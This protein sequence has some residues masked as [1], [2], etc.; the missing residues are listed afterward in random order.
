MDDTLPVMVIDDE[1]HLRI[2]V[3]Q[4]LELAGYQPQ[5]FESAQQ[6]LDHLDR[7][8]SGVL[9]SDIRMPGMDG[10]A[11]LREVHQR[12]PDLPVILIT[13]HGDISTAVEAMREGAW[14]FLE[15]PFS[16]EQLVEV[17]RRGID[18][19][20]LSLE[21]RY[22]KAE[23]E[24]QQSAPGPRLVGRTPVIK[25]LT[26]MVQRISQVE[27]DVLLFGE[28]GAGKDLVARAIHERSAR[29]VHPFVAINCGAVPESTIESE[30][31]GHEKGSF[32]G[33]IERRIGKFEYAQGG[34]VFLDEIESMPLA[35]QVKL[36]RVLQERMIERLGSNTPVELDIRV[37]AATKVDL[38][39]SAEAGE[40]R[41]DLY[42]RLNVVTLPIPSLRERREDIP[43]LF[44][45]FAAM[46]ANRSSMEA[47]PLDTASISALLA[48]DWPGNARELR[49]LAERY[50]LLGATCDYR[51]DGLM[52]GTDSD[53]G[54]LP[55]PRQVELFEKQLISQALVHHQGCISDVCKQLGVPRKTLY[56]KL[57]KHDLKPNHYRHHDRDD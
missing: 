29:S 25:H 42:Y 10:M 21:N 24:A 15:K 47:P 40:F 49:N 6:A 37:I 16:S 54:E 5:P 18:K 28:T 8:Y 12:D 38:K 31:F 45:H 52:E 33:A 50:V 19:R 27:A 23:L 46:A 2:T 57:R 22:L 7:D 26:S 51:L 32:T 20:R 11:L 30:L 53:S 3:G 55:L 9:I 35:L 44:Q 34:T 36:L 39:I 43:L 4:T 1:A 48:H 13:G 14:D 41:E 56:D 17:V